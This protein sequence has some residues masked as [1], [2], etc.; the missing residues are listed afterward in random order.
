MSQAKFIGPITIALLLLVWA[1]A[2]FGGL[3]SEVVGGLG[4]LTL[5]AALMAFL[6]FR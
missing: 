2:F 6:T 1:A 4:I 5:I 3:Q